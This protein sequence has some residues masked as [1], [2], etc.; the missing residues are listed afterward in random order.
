MGLETATEKKARLKREAEANGKGQPIPIP[1]P[2]EFNIFE[3]RK[4]RDTYTETIHR[5]EYLKSKSEPDNEE[6][7]TYLVFVMSD[8]NEVAFT[9]PVV[10]VHSLARASRVY[11]ALRSIIGSTVQVQFFAKGEAL[12]DGTVVDKDNYYTSGVKILFS[13]YMNQKAAE[14]DR[15]IASSNNSGF[16]IDFGDVKSLPKRS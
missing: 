16:A 10:V 5:L 7:G 14:L 1:N 11:Y 9:L 13:D 8:P 3:L 4:D 6:K 15:G 12:R 2:N